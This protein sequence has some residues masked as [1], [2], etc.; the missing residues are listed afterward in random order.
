MCRSMPRAEGGF[1]LIE[2]LVAMAV[3]SLAA[4]ALLNLAGANARTA[5]ALEARTFASVVADNRAVEALT[6]PAPPTLGVSQGTESAGGQPWRWTQRVSRTDDSGILRIDVLV[7]ARS[8][9]RTVAEVSV[10]RGPA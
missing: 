4:V 5:G 7:A 3:F 6:D 10:F 8:S 1:T 9:D 2:L